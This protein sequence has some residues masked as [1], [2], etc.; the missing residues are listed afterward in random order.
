MIQFSLALTGIAFSPWFRLQSDMKSWRRI[1]RREP[2]SEIDFLTTEA[3]VIKQ[4]QL[5]D[6]TINIGNEVYDVNLSDSNNRNGIEGLYYQVYVIRKQFP[7]TPTK[8]QL[9]S[10][11]RG[12]DDRI[13]NALILNIN[14]L[15]EL[16]DRDT[17]DI[18][19]KDPTI[20]GREETFAAGNDY[21]GLGAS[22]DI[23][24][25]DSTYEKFID[26]WTTHVKS[27]E[28]NMFLGD[29]QPKQLDVSLAELKNAKKDFTDIA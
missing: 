3:S 7:I 22:N 29:F 17:I 6:G 14:G 2:I 12:G 4:V 26:I 21:V 19:I 27:G 20:V 23:D 13:G 16:R 1:D 24:F 8:D 5:I 25:I 28:T 18:M 11:I 9:I 10:T 15:F